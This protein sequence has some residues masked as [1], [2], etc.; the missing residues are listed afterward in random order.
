MPILSKAWRIASPSRLELANSLRRA[1]LP[2]HVIAELLGESPEYI[3]RE[4]AE[5]RPV[6]VFRI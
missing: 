6:Y 1:G 2:T 5:H 3:R 4:T